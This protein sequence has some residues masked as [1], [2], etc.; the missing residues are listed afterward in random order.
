MI[1]NRTQRRRVKDVWYSWYPADY[2]AKTAHLTAVQDGI[3]RRL[4]DHYYLMHGRVVANATTLLRVCRAFDEAERAAVPAM[5]AEFFTVID[6]HYRHERADAELEKRA[7]LRQKRAEAGSKGGKQKVANATN[8]LGRLPANC[9]TQSQSQSQK[10]EELEPTLSS[11]PQTQ[12]SE[13][14]ASDAGASR[15]A[16]G[17]L[18]APKQELATPKP[19]VTAIDLE[20]QVWAI[21]KA[22][23]IESGVSPAQAGGLIGRW[24]KE[25]GFDDLE[26]LRLLRRAQAECVSE[27]KSF[28]EGCIKSLKGKSNGK[29]TARQFGRNREVIDDH[30]R[31]N[32]AAI[33]DRLRA[34]REGRDAFDA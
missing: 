33:A 19:V 17:E 27:P 13:A 6:G 31:G 24:R 29:A 5:L 21:G 34:E 11:I 25:L 7:L 9:Q 22:Y 3:Y 4:L 20:A 14:I 15:F 30:P 23:L 12:D 2:A 18:F 1:D 8:L 28:I 32:F 10:E 26:V 16:N